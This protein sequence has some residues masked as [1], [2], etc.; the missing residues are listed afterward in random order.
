MTTTYCASKDVAQLTWRNGDGSD[1]SASTNPTKAFVDD[2]INAGEDEIDATTR[3]SWRSTL[4][5]DEYRN[6]LID[7][8]MARRSWW[9]RGRAYLRH[10]NIRGFV[11]GTHKIEIFDGA[12]WIDLISGSYTEGRASDYWIDYEQG[13]IYF[14]NTYP[15]EIDQGVRVTYAYGAAT[16]PGDIKMCCAKM[17]AIDLV[18][19]DD[20]SI[21]VVEGSDNVRQPSKIEIWQASVER[22]LDKYMEIIAAE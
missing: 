14:V 5:S 2:L 3:H 17:A 7:W 8:S 13:I 15:Y 9:Y 6:Y 10:R 4:V 1:F 21:M 20:R 12:A 16:A 18:M 19:Q 22:T 11:S